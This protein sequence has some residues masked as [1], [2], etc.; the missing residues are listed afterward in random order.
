MVVRPETFGPYCACRLYEL[1][2]S[3]QA[4]FRSAKESQPFRNSTI[5]FS[6]SALVVRGGAKN[7]FAEAQTHSRWPWPVL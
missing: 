3:G 2:L 1:T 6:L 4:Q 7:V 5:I